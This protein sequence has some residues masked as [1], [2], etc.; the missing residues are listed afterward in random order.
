[1][2]RLQCRCCGALPGAFHQ[3]F[4]GIETC[5]RCGGQATICV[6]IYEECGIDYRTMEKEYPAI[7]ANGPTDEM[8]AI[9]DQGWDSRRIPWAGERHGLI[10]CRRLGLWCVWGPGW[11]SVP[12]GTP[13]AMEDLNSLFRKCDWDAVSQRWKLR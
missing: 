6:C 7:F 13:G 12:A 9:W 5:A 10:D 2:T 4:C 1:M 11:T 8:Y 3:F